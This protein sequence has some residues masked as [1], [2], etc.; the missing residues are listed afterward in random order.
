MLPDPL[1]PAVV[2]FPIVLAFLLPLFAVAAFWLARRSD[3]PRRV[4]LLPVLLAAGLVGSAFVA[5]RTGEAEEERVES[6]VSEAVLHDHEESAERFLLLS[7]VVLLLAGMGLVRGDV[8]RA[9]RGLTV[10]G[11]IAVAIAAV[12]VGAAGGDLVY[13]HN[14]ASVYADAAAATAPAHEDDD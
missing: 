14:A 9:A 2:H 7:G 10:A 6:V 5:L 13:R 4:W 11:S 3:Q 12:Q 8:G 1:H